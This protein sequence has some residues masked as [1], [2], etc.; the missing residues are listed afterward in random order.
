MA[1]TTSR[2]SSPSLLGGIDHSI[3]HSLIVVERG[4]LDVMCEGDVCGDHPAFGTHAK[5]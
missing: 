2:H 5:E 1:S 4:G 3:H